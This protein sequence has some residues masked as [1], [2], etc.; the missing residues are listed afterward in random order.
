MNKFRFLGNDL[1]AIEYD[2]CKVVIIPAPLE[3]TVSYGKGASQAPTAILKASG[4]IELYDEDLGY[5]PSQCGIYTHVGLS[6]SLSQIDFLTELENFFL[7]IKADRKL[8]II[9]GGEHSLSIA[10]IKALQKI[11]DINFTVLQFDAHTDLRDIYENN[12]LSHACVMRRVFELGIPIIAVGIR[13]LSKEE[14]EFISAN[15]IKIFYVRD[16]M[17][18]NHWMKDAVSLLAENIYITFDVDVFDPSI[19]S[20]TGTP[21]PGGLSWYQILQFFQ[22]IKQHGKNI[23]GIDVVEFSPRANH[24]AQS[25]TITKLI[26]K[27]IGYFTN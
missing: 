21:E 2:D 11:Y 25:F 6:N 7:K 12:K 19:I 23:L 13:S 15:K 17:K 20:H 26:Y 18:E 1:P 3:K 4:Y 10:P 22:M 5:E 27:M 14:A 9:I 8:P 16:L 24:E